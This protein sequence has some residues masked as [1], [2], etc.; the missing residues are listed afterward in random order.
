MYTLVAFSSDMVM[1]KR[2]GGLCEA[3]HDHTNNTAICMD[4]SRSCRIS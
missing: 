1:K 4:C 3:A 2:A